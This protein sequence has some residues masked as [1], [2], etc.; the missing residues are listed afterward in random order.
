MAA[1]GASARSLDRGVGA[2]LDA[3]D[4]LGLRDDTLVIC[5]TDHGM[6]FPGAK[7]T[8]TDRGHR[9]LPDHARAG[10]LRGR[11]RSIDA[12]VS[13]IDLFPTVCDLPAI[14]PPH[15]LQGESHA[16]ARARRGR[17]SA[18][19]SSP[20]A[21][22][23]P[24]TSR[25]ARSARRAGSTS[26]ASTTGRTPC[27]STPTT[28]PARTLWLRPAG[29][30]RP[31]RRSSSTTSCSTRT[32]RENLIDRDEHAPVRADL[33]ARSSRWMAETDDPLLDGPVPPPPGAEY[34]E[35][36]QVSPG[37]PTRSAPVI[38]REAA[39]SA[40]EPGAAPLDRSPASRSGRAATARRQRGQ[41]ERE[42]PR[43]DP[44]AEAVGEL[45]GG[46]AGEGH[47]EAERDAAARQR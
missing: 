7:A 36:D 10:R 16:A 37:E 38:G 2:V 14:A 45:V 28:A 31:W 3:L 34:N 25:S 11:A 24:P 32:R 21:P 33:R 29:P 35:P 12:L 26:A 18:T 43:A 42:G 47:T 30:S 1:F 15:W 46:G 22:T 8:L 27:W 19:R 23:T 9:R 20:R 39:G 40:A 41:A 17:R 13:H 5:T 6:A 4:D 44:V